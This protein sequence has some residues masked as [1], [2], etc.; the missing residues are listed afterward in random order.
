MDE[1][2]AVTGEIGL[3]GELRSV[4]RAD[5]RVAE[6]ARLGFASCIIPYASSYA[7]KVRAT[8]VVRPANIAEAVRLALKNSDGV[9]G[10]V[11]EASGSGV[12]SSM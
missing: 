1:T 9:T 11:S 4:P 7:G 12:R 2:V 5:R 10:T 6:A 8:K 3:S